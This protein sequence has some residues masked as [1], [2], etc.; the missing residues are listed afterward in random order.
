MECIVVVVVVV[1][2]RLFVMPCCRPNH[3]FDL[4]FC[5]KEPSKISAYVSVASQNAQLWIFP[6]VF[7]SFFPFFFGSYFIIFVS[8]PGL[9]LVLIYFSFFQLMYQITFKLTNRLTTKKTVISF[10]L[11]FFWTRILFSWHSLDPLLVDLEPSAPSRITLPSR[12]NRFVC[13]SR[14]IT[15]A[16]TILLGFFDFQIT[17][18]LIQRPILFTKHSFLSSVS[19]YPIELQRNREFYRNA[20]VRPPFTYASLI[21]QVCH[22]NSFTSIVNRNQ[23]NFLF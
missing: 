11:F 20:D 9:N 6:K 13:T 19:N 2:C 21:R 10:S 12:S 5:L 16:F 17:F 22:M 4:L 8:L 23:L 7:I 18:D 1:E 14:Y 3:C 15:I